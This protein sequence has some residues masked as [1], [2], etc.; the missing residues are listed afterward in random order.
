MQDGSVALCLVFFFL[1]NSHT[2]LCGGCIHLHSHQLVSEGIPVLF[3]C[4]SVVEKHETH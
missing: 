3:D 2:V 4:V 1:R